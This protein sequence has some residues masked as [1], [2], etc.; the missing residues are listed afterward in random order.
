[1]ARRRKLWSPSSEVELASMVVG[2]L[3]QDSWDVY[4]EVLGA[5]IVAVRG[6]VLWVVECKKTMGFPVLEQAMHWRA[7]ANGVW[8]ATPPRRQCHRV[9]KSFCSHVGVGWLE[10]EPRNSR[11]RVRPQF[12]RRASTGR[13]RSFLRPEH[14]TYAAAGSPTGR[15]WTP[16]KETCRS[17]LA[18]VSASPGISLREAMKEVSHHYSSD[19]SARR[20]L[21]A[22]LVKGAVPGIRF[23]TSGRDVLLFP[24]K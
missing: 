1:M 22:L 15:T 16:Y 12:N 21:V 18:R 3:E 17:L 19:S 10:V 8:V 6:P 24:S 20:S 4:Q 11:P 14:K 13:I 23:E 5:D 9:I 7:E 2:W